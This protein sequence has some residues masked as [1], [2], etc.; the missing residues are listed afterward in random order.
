LKVEFDAP[1]FSSKGI[2]VRM[3]DGEV[4]IYLNRDGL[5][6]LYG[7]LRNLNDSIDATNHIHVGDY[8]ILTENSLGLVIGYFANP[9]S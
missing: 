7:M 1:K 5:E 2:E 6:C 9:S 3:K 8:G 4:A